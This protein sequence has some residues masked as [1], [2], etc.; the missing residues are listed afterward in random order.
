[1]SIGIY[2]NPAQPRVR[3]FNNVAKWWQPQMLIAILATTISPRSCVATWLSPMLCPWPSWHH[4]IQFSGRPSSTSGAP[5]A[6]G[7]PLASAKSSRIPSAADFSLAF[8]STSTSSTTLSFS[9]TATSTSVV[10]AKHS[11]AASMA[12]GLL[13]EGLPREG[14]AARSTEDAKSCCPQSVSAAARRP[15]T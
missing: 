4:K 15:S 13:R 11:R 12:K 2:A 6:P 3:G 8:S 5:G 1:M 14:K 10:S 9:S 7:H